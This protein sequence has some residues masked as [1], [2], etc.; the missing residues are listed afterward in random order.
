MLDLKQGDLVRL[1]SDSDR[2]APM[3]VEF[4]M[5]TAIQLVWRDLGGVMHRMP[6]DI[7]TLKLHAGAE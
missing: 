4:I 3:C 2:A 1:K 6:A 5:G 7:R